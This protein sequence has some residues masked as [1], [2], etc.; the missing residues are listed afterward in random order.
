MAKK[1]QQK[2]QMRKVKLV[3]G[4]K[5]NPKYQPN[6]LPFF[7]LGSTRVPQ[8]RRATVYPIGEY[9]NF[10]N[11]VYTVKEKSPQKLKTPTPER[12]SPV[13]GFR[14]S[15]H[16]KQVEQR[17]KHIALQKAKKSPSPTP[18]KSSV[19]SLNIKIQNIKKLK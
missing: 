12:V 8:T 19:N 4:A 15:P 3:S 7:L 17:Q 16:K 6:K 1:P 13:A 2:K 14:G 18:S 9:R 11:K 10:G 5:K